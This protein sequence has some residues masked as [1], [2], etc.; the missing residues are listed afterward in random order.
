MIWSTSIIC[1]PLKR[2]EEYL[3]ER[4][5]DQARR[6]NLPAF[7][8]LDIDFP[9]AMQGVDILDKIKKLRQFSNI[10]VFIFTKNSDKAIVANC[11]VRGANGY[12]L[13]PTESAGF[14]HA[15]RTLTERW[16]QII[17]RGFGYNYKAV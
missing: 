5:P 4:G 10:P 7:I 16:Q 6:M 15:V 3:T 1:H 14:T 11:Y 9:N 8:I 17:Q 2:L 13:K 12:F